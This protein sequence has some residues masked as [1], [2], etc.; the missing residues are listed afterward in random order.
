MFPGYDLFRCASNADIEV[1]S[2]MLRLKIEQDRL[3][4][5]GEEAG[6]CPIDNSPAFARY[7]QADE[8]KV[9]SI[10]KQIKTVLDRLIRL[11]TIHDTSPSE[12]R[13]TLGSSTMRTVDISSPPVVSSVQEVYDKL[14]EVDRGQPGASKYRRGLNH[15][16]RFAQDVFTISQDPKRLGWAIKDRKAFSV[17]LDELKSFTDHLR[18]TISDEKTDR[19]LWSSHQ[20]W[21][22]VLQLTTTVE[23]MKALLDAQSR[24]SNNDLTHASRGNGASILESQLDTTIKKVTSFAILTSMQR[25]KRSMLLDLD[26]ASNLRRLVDVDDGYRTPASFNNKSVWIEWRDYKEVMVPGDTGIPETHPEPQSVQN[27]ERLA[28]LLSQ[29][30]QPDELHLPTCLGYIEDADDLRF[31]LVLESP[32]G[33]SESLLALFNNRDANNRSKCAVA[34]QIADGVL[35]LHAV[36]WLHKGLRS[37]GLMFSKTASAPG[38]E[39]GRLLISGFGFS[40]PSDNSFTSSGPSHDSKWS[41]Y[42]HP[43]YLDENRKSGYRKAYDI[44]SLGIILIE[45]ALWKPIDQ[46]LQPLHS[47][48][49]SALGNER[50]NTRT[51]I[52]DSNT[53][54][55]QVRLNMSDEYAKATR[56]CI[57]GLSAFGLS[58]DADEANPY[59][60]ALLQRAFIEVVVDPLEDITP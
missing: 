23:D 44:Y 6:L 50:Q 40:R 29:T 4:R 10:L 46:V 37:A 32:S 5:W 17:G 55:E 18:E 27:V 1:K 60:A 19:N 51:R 59:V 34:R 47:G 20:T 24:T 57:E 15:I 43:A 31:G 56:A 33:Q 16:F 12:P 26:D 58:D 28:W 41:L 3:S 48:R 13:S 39:L 35:Y 42:C 7:I 52:L 38:D 9:E 14:M 11:T 36:N 2:F 22:S 25:A 49:D 53:I 54:L 21:L 45:I 8:T 30:G